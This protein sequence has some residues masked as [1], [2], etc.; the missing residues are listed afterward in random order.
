MEDMY[1]TTTKLKLATALDFIPASLR[2]MLQHLFVGKDTSRKVAGIGQAVIQAVSPR[3]VFAPLQ[4]DVAM[5]M[6]HLYRSRFLIDSLS[7]MGFASSY[8]EVQRFEMNV[9]CSLAPDVLGS[10]M[11][12]L[13]QSLL[14]AGDNMDHNI[15]TLDGKGTFHGMGMI[16]AI[17]PGKQVS[18]GIPQ[19]KQPT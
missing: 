4:L 2:F 3:A 1:P 13:G 17:T 5:Q 8:P 9:A 10:D 12:I 18:Q 14:F 16:A 19:Q 11:D 7:T 15:I 6:H